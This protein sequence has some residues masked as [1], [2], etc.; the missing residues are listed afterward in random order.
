MLTFLPLLLLLLIVLLVEILSRSKLNIGNQWL[1]LILSS[2]LVLGATIFL[3]AHL[4]EPVVIKN[5]LEGTAY[6]IVFQ[7]DEKSWVFVFGLVA[8]LT[9]MI[10]TDTIHLHER[11]NL[12]SWSRILLLFCLGI[13]GTLANSLMAFILVWTIIDVV[14]LIVHIASTKGISISDQSVIVFFA[15]LVGDILMVP[16]LV[17]Q[18]ANEATLSGLSM[19]GRDISLLILAAALRMPVYD[20]VRLS[21]EKR[22]I[23]NTLQSLRQLLS[24]FLAMVLLARLPRIAELGS[25]PALFLVLAILAAIAAMFSRFDIQ[26]NKSAIIVFCSLA[27][28]SFLRGHS[29]GVIGWALLMLTLLGF[30]QVY[31]FTQKGFIPL[32]GLIGLAAIGLP[33]S[34]SSSA[35]ASLGVGPLAFFNFILWIGLAVM[36]AAIIRDILKQTAET[37][38]EAWMRLLYTI[39]L[40]ILAATPWLPGIWKTADNGMDPFNWQSIAILI[41]AVLII[42]GYSNQ[43]VKILFMELVPVQLQ[44]VIARPRRKPIRQVSV[45]RVVDFFYDL[46]RKGIQ[47][48]NNVLEGEGGLLWA[49]VLLVLLLSLLMSKVGG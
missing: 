33:V 27:I 35:L 44:E 30:V 3:R 25:F 11:V 36:L 22:Q 13:L 43:R 14:E 10:F 45:Y 19:T 2:T 42:L 17:S 15:H 48:V 32:I 40:V 47:A 26:K 28:I 12:H 16:V 38:P 8:F 39:G 4:P 6:Q 41:I 7:L 46:M 37:T 1:I 31:T 34:V 18:T 9:A 29:E 5:W 20:K 49:F 24:P 21:K 23:D